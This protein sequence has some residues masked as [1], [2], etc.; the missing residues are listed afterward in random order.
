[1]RAMRQHPL[2]IL[3][4]SAPADPL[5]A[6]LADVVRLRDEVKR[7]GAVRVESWGGRPADPARS[8]K[9]FE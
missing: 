7:Q 8:A 5:I 4:P 6:L 1:M 3:P 9:L 2:E